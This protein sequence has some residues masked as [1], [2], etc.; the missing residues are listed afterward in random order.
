MRNTHQSVTPSFVFDDP[1]YAGLAVERAREYQN[2]QPF[3]H[4]AIDGFLPPAL[5]TELADAFPVQD[6]TDWIIRDNANNRRRFLQDERKMPEVFRHMCREFNSPQ[7]LLFLE[8][9]TGIDNLL[10][11]PYLIAGGL[12]VSGRGD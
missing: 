10:P 9:L 12:H 11:D 2:A 7:F 4:V 6:Q 8:T 3:P 5:A 1:A